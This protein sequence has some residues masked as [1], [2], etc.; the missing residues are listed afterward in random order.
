MPVTGQFA[1]AAS[2]DV[3]VAFWRRIYNP[4]DAYGGK[5]ITGWAARLYPY[6]TWRGVAGEPNPLLD[7][8]IDEPRDLTAPGRMGYQGPG[9]RSDRVPAVLSKV[10]VNVNDVAGGDNPGGGP[11][12]RAGRRHPG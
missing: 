1:R 3:D 5:V 4:A 2:G 11:A 10:M 12:R 6:L 8:P 7:L 9:I